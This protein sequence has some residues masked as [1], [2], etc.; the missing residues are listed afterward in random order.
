MGLP[1]VRVLTTLRFLMLIHS[2]FA[3][4]SQLATA[5]CPLAVKSMWFTPAHGTGI[6]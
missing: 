6:G 1:S 2:S 4:N 5:S 3:L